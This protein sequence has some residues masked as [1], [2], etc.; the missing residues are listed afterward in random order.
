MADYASA[1][2]AQKLNVI[3]GGI[4]LLGFNPQSGQSASFA[5]V[6]WVSVSPKLY[7]AECAIEIVLEDASG[8]PVSLPGPGGQPQVL[9]IGQAVRFEEPK[10]RPGVPRHVLRARTQWV[11]GFPTGLPLPVGQ[12]LTW[13]V[14]I[15][16]ESRPDW[17]DE[18]YIPGPVSGPVLG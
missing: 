6:V 13:R 2:A 12:A 8:N 18:F 11:V 9:R 17:S 7:N 4:S 15:D 14:K 1:D 3:G 5:L 10:L 16:H